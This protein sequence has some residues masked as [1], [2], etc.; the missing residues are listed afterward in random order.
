M[1]IQDVKNALDQ[2]GLHAGYFRWK[3]ESHIQELE[4]FYIRSMVNL[5]Q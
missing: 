5:G 2:Y 1:K 3:K 4:N